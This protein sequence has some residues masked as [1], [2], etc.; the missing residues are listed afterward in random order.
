MRAPRRGARAY[1]A[2]VIYRTATRDDLP[3]VVALLADGDDVVDPASVRP[4]VDQ[5]R[6][7]ETVAGD[8]RNELLVLEKDG[9][10]VGC[11][12]ATYIPDLGGDC[13]ERAHLE[14]VRVRPDFRHNGFGRLLVTYAIARARARG[15][16]LVQLTTDKSHIEAQRF[17]ASLGFVPSH[18]GFKLP[19]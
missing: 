8:P 1:A 3:A 4:G 18:E 9:T 19:L 5:V 14:A 12:Q 13:S 15:C 11:I 17:C 10:V 7:F 2:G 6:A 16:T